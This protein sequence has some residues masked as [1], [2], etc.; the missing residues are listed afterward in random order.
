MHRNTLLLIA[1]L[2]IIA[3]F[4]IGINVARSLNP[5][6]TNL[7]PVV[8][9]SDPSPTQSHLQASTCG[10]SYRYPNLFTAKESSPS[11]TVL[12]NTSDPFDTITITCQ[13]E[14]PRIPLPSEKIEGVIIRAAT[15]TASVS[16]KLYHD[17]SQ[18][19]GTPIDKLIFTHPKTKLD[20]FIAGFG[21]SF[22]E[23]LS[24]LKFQ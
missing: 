1:F 3:T 5:S 6:L 23:F 19:D 13:N 11:G 21:K 10:L 16:A 8:P 12:M 7:P 14:I 24:T 20:I 4:L 18:R 22:Q 17:T 2:A 9:T 15:G